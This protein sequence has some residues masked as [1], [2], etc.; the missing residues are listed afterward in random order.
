M[1]VA[2]SWKTRGRIIQAG[3]DMDISS[4]LRQRGEARRQFVIRTGRGGDP[5]ALGNA[6]AVEPEEETCFRVCGLNAAFDLSGVQRAVGIKH[7]LER[8]QRNGCRHTFE[9]SPARKF[10]SREH[11]R[12]LEK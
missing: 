10:N 2:R 12:S 5:I 6:V 1:I 3:D 4:E 9:Q 7:G 11:T 8:W